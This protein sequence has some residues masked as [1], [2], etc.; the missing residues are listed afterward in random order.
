LLVNLRAGIGCASKLMSTRKAGSHSAGRTGTRRSAPRADRGPARRS[1]GKLA[2]SAYRRAPLT[3]LRVFVA[4][5]DHMSFTRGADALGLTT[6]A[7]SMQIQSLEDYLGVALLRRNGR[8]VELTAAGVA[9]WPKVERALADLER[10]IDEARADR[11]SGPLRITT[12][13][14]FLAQWL[15]PRLPTFTALHPAIDV[16]IETSVA[17][18]DFV[19]ESADVGIRCGPGVWPRLHAEKLFDEWLVPVC[20]PALLKSHG[21]IAEARDL[22]RYQLLHS[23]YE[24]WSAWL[25]EG[26]TQDIWPR[27]GP[28]FDDAV[29]IVRAAEAGQGLALARWSLVA[30]DV[31]R[32]R[33]AVAGRAVRSRH[34][35]HFV[36]PSAH[37]AMSKVA[38]FR[39]WLT[40]E[41]SRFPA[42]PALGT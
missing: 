21:T 35:W 3:S 4:V 5:A 39:S 25:L 34:G 41:S 15:L 27:S 19:K 26:A 31:S 37:L 33:L 2:G 36:C 40:Q 13:A 9:L 28:A 17:L 18:S 30:D 24:P 7:A 16:Q 23:P 8:H 29:A 42:P 1:S 32:A 12:L 20:T 11:G 38:A 10:A 6:S 14:F 22:S